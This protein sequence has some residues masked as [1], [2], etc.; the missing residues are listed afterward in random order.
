[1]AVLAVA[2]VGVLGI[3]FGTGFGAE[4]SAEPTVA[5]FLLD[6]QQGRYA[7][8]AALTNGDREQV[9]ARLS[10]AHI[11]LNATATFF[12]MGTI[13]SRGDTA[14]ASFNAT[15]NL[16][17]GGQ[18]WTYTGRFVLVAK[19]G[20]WLVDWAPSVVNP[21]LGPGD[22]LAVVTAFAPRAQVQDVSGRPLVSESLDYHVGVYPGRLANASRTAAM[23]SSVA[24]L[25]TQQVLGQ[26]EAAP[27]REFLSLL[28]LEPGSFRS[29][30]PKL[31]KVPGLTS[32]RKS[33]RLFD[34][35]ADD[36]VG[37]VGTENSAALRAEGA[38][39]QPG[40]T[41][42]LSGLQQAYQ[43]SMVGTPTTRVVVVNAAGRVTTTLW[44]SQ[45]RS[46]TPVRTT[47]NGQDQAAAAGVLAQQPNSAEIVAVDSRAGAILALAS[48]QAGGTPLPAGGALNSKLK[49]GMAFSIVSAAALLSDGIQPNTR[50]PC[51]DV[52]TV[53][54]QSFTYS[55]AQQSSTTFASDFAAGCGTAFATMS[56]RLNPA[57]LAE[58]E[59]SFGI[60]EG[61]TLQV[62]AYSGSASA[63]RDEASLATQVIGSGG[64]LV[65]PLSMALVAAEVEAGIGHAPALI[66]SD[67]A[68]TRQVP[69]SV[70]ELGQLRGLMRQAVRSGSAGAAD[71]PG[72]PVYGQAGVV[73]TGTHAYLSWF[74]GYR[75]GTAIAVIETGDTAAQAAASLAG[76]FFRATALPAGNAGLDA[77]YAGPLPKLYSF[78]LTQ[79]NQTDTSWRLR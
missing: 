13:T 2:V 61:W 26:I 28:T 76:D 5:A 12:S 21:S 57:Q 18:Q 63:A 16:A 39:Y 62:P 53:G 4:S 27:P 73:R 25:N 44:T 68:A 51:Q 55:L 42:G 31:T 35:T 79:S 41:V 29:L 34:T 8:A 77:G 58:A 3:G 59:K 17:Q 36:A 19:D 60:G 69:L 9:A 47:L 56:L 64:V 43:E 50:L 11:E 32:Q 40:A 74:V 20:H 24:G 7:A 71:V 54:G 37:G 48:H 10:A 45:G 30:R 52:T 38:A 72:Q 6:W 67:P 33:E 70:G 46:G 49:P 15:V 14:Q 65:S 78:L 75:G 1:M 22:R 23:F 66:A